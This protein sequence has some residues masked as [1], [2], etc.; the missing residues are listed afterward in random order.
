MRVSLWRSSGPIPPL[1]PGNY[2][3]FPGNYEP[4]LFDSKC[5]IQGK[6]MGVTPIWTEQAIAVL[7]TAELHSFAWCSHSLEAQISH[8]MLE[9]FPEIP[10]Q[11]TSWL[12]CPLSQKTSPLC[13][14]VAC[15]VFMCDRIFGSDCLTW[16]RR[17]QSAFFAF[18][19]A[20]C[21][22]QTFD[23]WKDSVFADTL[24][25][26]QNVSANGLLGSNCFS[27]CSCNHSR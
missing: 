17:I 8:Q 14:A 2:E 19:L 18:Q 27:L 13:S 23:L 24:H 10:G 9:A 5:P 16:T 3:P 4:T 21:L 25:S 7:M 11:C 20:P 26:E 15:A 6:T 12:R 1:S 22:F